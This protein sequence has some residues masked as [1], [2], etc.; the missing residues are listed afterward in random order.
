MQE[1]PPPLHPSLFVRCLALL[2]AALCLAL[3]VIGIFVPGLP[4]TVFILMA[5][6]FAARG[7]PRLLAWMERHRVFG[8]MIRHWRTDRSVSRRAKWSATV[9]MATCA[10]ILFVAPIQP[11]AAWV[12][13]GIMLTVA[14]WLWRRPEPVDGR[15]SATTPDRDPDR[16]P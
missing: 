5:A 8:P 10:A 3:G 1:R 15:T 9:M 4:T 14:I 6:W 12:A 16:R 7:S 13:G 2:A 11:W